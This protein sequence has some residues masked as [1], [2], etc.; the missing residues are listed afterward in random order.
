MRLKPVCIDVRSL[1]VWNYQGAVDE[2]SGSIWVDQQ[3]LEEEIAISRFIQNIHDG[4]FRQDR[5]IN[6]H[7]T[8]KMELAYRYNGVAKRLHQFNVR[9]SAFDF[10]NSRIFAAP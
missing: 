1:L 2:Q 6:E 5:G 4:A 7:R 3:Q 9:C 10:G 8:L